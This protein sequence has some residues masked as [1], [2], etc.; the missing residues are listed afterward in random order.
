MNTATETPAAD[1]KRMNLSNGRE[2]LSDSI[3]RQIDL[4][5]IVIA[6]LG[7][8]LFAA[9]LAVVAVIDLVKFIA[10][11]WSDSADRCLLLIFGTAIVWVVAR[12]KH[13]SLY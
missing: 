7:M 2:G 9:A 1:S 6:S 13:S 8:C 10:S 11:H 12:W 3:L 5:A 4:A